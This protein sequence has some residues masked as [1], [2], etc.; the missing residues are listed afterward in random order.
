MPW[1][2]PMRVFLTGATGYLGSN[3]LSRLLVQGHQVMAHIRD[4]NAAP[5]ITAQGATPVLGDLTDASWL[6]AQLWDLDGFVHTASPNDAT[7]A[8]LDAAVLGAVLPALAG[9]PTVYVHT[10]GTWIH[11]NGHNIT[12]DS[13]FLPPSIVAWRPAVVKQ[14]R[15]AAHYGVH[16]VVVAPANLYGHHGGIPALIANGPRAHDDRPALLYPGGHQHMS[17]V[18]V[19]DI[20]ALFTLALTTAPAG[21]YYLGANDHSPTMRDVAVAASHGQGLDGRVHQEADTDTRAR[22]G[23]LTDALMLDQRID[24]SHARALGWQATGPSLLDEL[25]AGSYAL[26]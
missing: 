7:S 17:N 5:T 1:E 26:Q 2:I 15:D 20:A 9:T 23:P 8:A 16:A 11:G 3:V 21:S 25:A 12:E 14:V 6:R 13:P 24:T 18:Y 19:D 4:E 10:A 22:L